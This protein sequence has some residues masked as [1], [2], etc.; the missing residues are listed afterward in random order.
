VASK[1]TLYAK[2]R[3]LTV[4]RKPKESVL[5]YLQRIRQ[6]TIVL[7]DEF[8]REVMD[9][10]LWQEMHLLAITDE[11][12]F[13]Y[14]L[15]QLFAVVDFS[16]EGP[17]KLAFPN[18]EFAAASFWDW[19][20]SIAKALDASLQCFILDVT[21]HTL[22]ME[23]AI[24]EWS[25]SFRKRYSQLHDIS[26][27]APEAA[28]PRRGEAAKAT[29]NGGSVD[30]KKKKGAGGAGGASQEVASGPPKKGN[31]S[32]GAPRKVTGCLNCGK[33]TCNGQLTCYCSHCKRKYVAKANPAN[34]DH[35][36]CCWQGNGEGQCASRSAA[37]RGPKHLESVDS[38]PA[39]PAPGKRK[40][41]PT[42][43]E[44]AE[45]TT[46]AAVPSSSKKPRTESAAANTNNK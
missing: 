33:T 2:L 44:S 21:K 15:L 45:D 20:Q 29:N 19:L 9:W 18:E 34:P 4:K 43:E 11:H 25:F 16:K 26:M 38:T 41:T 46:Q 42:T 37:G 10:T 1:N 3:N 14:L 28:V 32:G 39:P 5:D 17:A 40:V 13:A 36:A 35:Q 8:P 31:G 22:Y 6:V 30:G 23:G 27:D 7:R 12:L 24:A